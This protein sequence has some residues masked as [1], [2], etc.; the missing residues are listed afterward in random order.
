MFYIRQFLFILSLS[1]FVLTVHGQVSLTKASD[2]K[3]ESG[4][5]LQDLNIIEATLE[6]AINAYAE[7]GKLLDSNGQVTENSINTFKGLFTP[8][9]TLLRDYGEFIADQPIDLQDYVQEVYNLLRSRGIEMN[10]TKATFKEIKPEGS[11]FYTVVVEVEKT[12]FNSVSA[13][14]QVNTLTTGDPLKELFYFDIFKEDLEVAT[15]QSITKDKKRGQ[16]KS[17]NL[18]PDFYERLFSISLTAGS[19]SWNPTLSTFWNEA[20]AESTFEVEGGINFGLGFE[21]VTDRFITSR[22]NSNRR[23]FWSLGLGYSAI[24]QNTSLGSFSIE[25]FEQTAIQATDTENTNRYMR[26]VGPVFAE[27][28]LRFDMINIPLGIGYQVS[29]S[30]KSLFYIHAR[31][32]PSFIFG[33]SGGV[34]GTGTYD[35]TYIIDDPNLSLTPLFGTLSDF[36]LLNSGAVDQDI[37]DQLNSDAAFKDFQAGEDQVLGSAQDLSELPV[38]PELSSIAFAVQLSPTVYIKLNDDNPGWGILAGLDLGYHLGSFITHNPATSNLSDA[39]KY[40][41]DFEGSL[42]SYY[43]TKVSG[44][45]FG[46]RLGIFQRLR[47]EP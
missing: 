20:H 32:I 19:A 45:S 47:S 25:P 41:D 8:S 34:S 28:E 11:R 29:K 43:A 24:Q 30:Q 6:R 9:A 14:G 5:S 15:I 26:L 31:F 4:V 16:V 37:R 39:F 2:L 36:S 33:S 10:V 27:E 22:T 21:F 40:N 3:N 17:N 7:A 42:L 38:D 13:N 1:N 18:V 44:L 35:A 23:I 46:L 12:R